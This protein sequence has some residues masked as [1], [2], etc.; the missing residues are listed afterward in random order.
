[1]LF[2]P[3]TRI[4]LTKLRLGRSSLKQLKIRADS[5]TLTQLDA[6]R[7]MRR[8]EEAFA[9]LGPLLDESPNPVSA[10]FTVIDGGRA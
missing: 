4:D 7:F 5:E 9:E 3:T 1:M 2:Q 6:E 10:P 8:I